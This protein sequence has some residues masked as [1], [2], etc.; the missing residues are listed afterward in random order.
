MGFRF[1]FIL[2][3]YFPTVHSEDINTIHISIS[4][5]HLE[6]QVVL[7]EDMTIFNNKNI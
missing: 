5:V 3:F 1:L 7:R 4:S 6:E 2:K